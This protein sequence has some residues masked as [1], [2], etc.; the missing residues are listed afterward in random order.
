MYN[1]IEFD[2]AVCGCKVKKSKLARH[3]KS[4]GHIQ[5]VEGGGGDESLGRV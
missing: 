3:V 5:G 1:Q 4:N 2:C